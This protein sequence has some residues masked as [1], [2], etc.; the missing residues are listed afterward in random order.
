MTEPN[1]NGHAVVIREQPLAMAPA[2]ISD[3]EINRTWRLAVA[4]AKSRFFKDSL[5]AEQAF[6]K[7]LLGRDLGLSPTQAMVN[8][9]IVEGK[10]EV[11]ANLQAQFVREYVGPTGDR[12]DYEILE[13]TDEACT[14]EFRRRRGGSDEWEVLGKDGPE[15]FTMEDAQTAG[16][17]RPTKSGA[18]SMY[19]KYPR[20]MLFARC[21]SNGVA[22]N[23]PEVNNG[24]R[25]YYPGEVTDLDEPT[26]GVE[27]TADAEGAAEE[28]PGADGPEVEPIDAEV[29]AD[30][31]GA[32]LI[33]LAADVVERKVW[34]RRKLNA[35][36]VAHG[37]TSTHTYEAAVASMTPADCDALASTIADALTAA[38]TGDEPTEAEVP[39]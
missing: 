36:F 34:T 35:Q 14:I 15:R 3:A 25:L 19:V 4:L 16:L 17:T 20:N 6:A 30:D 31:A 18:P 1:G 9:N 23:C 32:R 10:P 26:P 8:I 2:L 37:A 21:M 39:A 11:S 5:Q 12:Y 7:M 24:H 13:H 33:G 38:E 22:F 29:V 27:V 28:M